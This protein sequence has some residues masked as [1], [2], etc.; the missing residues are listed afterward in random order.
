VF[1]GLVSS[2]PNKIGKKKFKNEINVRIVRFEVPNEGV[3]WADKFD[4]YDPVFFE[5]HHL[6]GA[7]WADP[8]MGTPD[9]S[10]NFNQVDG[11]IDRRSHEGEYK[12]K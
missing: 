8:A 5:A 6:E 2:H 3:P 9:F 1:A 4:N 10:P 11:K 12:V 7:P